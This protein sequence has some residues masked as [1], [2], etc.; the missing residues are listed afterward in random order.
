MRFR[1]EEDAEIIDGE[2]TGRSEPQVQQWI[3]A[4]QP[5]VQQI[6][7]D[8]N[9]IAGAPGGYTPGPGVDLT[10]LID[11]GVNFASQQQTRSLA[12]LVKVPLFAYVAMHRKMPVVVRLGAAAFGVMEFLEALQ[13]APD[14]E[15]MMQLPPMPGE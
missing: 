5:G 2:V 9:V 10:G 4:A 1:G 8:P 7:M 14:Y 6:P 12:L 15:Q 3:S 11:V 13:R